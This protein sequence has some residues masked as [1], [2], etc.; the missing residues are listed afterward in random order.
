[1]QI[2]ETGLKQDLQDIVSKSQSFKKDLKRQIGGNE[3][4]ENKL[5]PEEIKTILNKYVISG[6]PTKEFWDYWSMYKQ[7]FKDNGIY[8]AKVDGKFVLKTKQEMGQ[9]INPAKTVKKLNHLS[10]E[11]KKWILNNCVNPDGTPTPEFWDHW[12]VN[13]DVMKNAGLY[14]Y[15]EGDKFVLKTAGKQAGGVPI[16]KNLKNYAPQQNPPLPS[17]EDHPVESNFDAAE[18]LPEFPS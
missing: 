6:V 16:K 14:I 1:M 11:Q 3:M 8:M 13:K 9:M 7:Q 5:S 12:R 15:K 4:E 10:D 17:P 18:G 2:L